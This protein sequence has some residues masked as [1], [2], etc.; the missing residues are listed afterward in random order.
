MAKRLAALA[1]VV[2]LPLAGPGTGALGFPI[3]PLN[4]GSKSSAQTGNTGADMTTR[5]G[6]S[7]S[8]IPLYPDESQ[9]GAMAARFAPAFLR[10]DLS[11]LAA[12]DRQALSK[13]LEAARILNDIFLDQSW[14][15][16]RAFYRTLQHDATGLGRA[17]QHYYW[18]CPNRN[19]LAPT[20]IPKT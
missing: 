3:R 8:A 14:S 16:G 20:C 7:S 6:A 11:G 2:L 18:V 12:G 10:A 19:R 4:G 13:L 15:N 5:P 17:R 1:V 9:L